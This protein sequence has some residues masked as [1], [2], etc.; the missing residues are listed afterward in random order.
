MPNEKIK[1]YAKI[2]GVPLWRVANVLNIHE[3]VF[4]RRLRYELP[5]E[6]QTKI[7]SIIDVLAKNKKG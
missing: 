7:C 5:P 2:K 4:S 3:S 1:K 6:V